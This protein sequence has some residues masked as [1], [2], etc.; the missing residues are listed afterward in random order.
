VDKK[1]VMVIDDEEDFLAMTKMNLE[2]TN[3]YVVMTL[4]KAK[5]VLFYIHSFKPDVILLDML[6][7]KIGGIE[8]CE[9]L[10]ED[11]IG[12]NIPIIIISALG[13]DVDKLSAYKNGVV[14]YIVKPAELNKIVFAIDK[15]LKYR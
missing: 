5:D 15:V 6:M 4:A 7:P 11:L 3:K 1:K 2:K 12:K 14:D 13:K 10:N 8:V 9:A